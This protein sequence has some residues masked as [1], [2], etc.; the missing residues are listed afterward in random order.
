M[1]L[2]NS[3][4]ES[5]SIEQASLND[6]FI[7]ETHDEKSSLEK[8]TSMVDAV[9]ER[10]EENESTLAK[11]FDVSKEKLK[12]MKA[13]YLDIVYLKSF[14]DTALEINDTFV[15]IVINF[16]SKLRDHLEE[17]YNFEP[18]ECKEENMFRDMGIKINN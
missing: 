17:I 9:V 3:D 2:D 12:I 16:L 5:T 4:N 14:Y 13:L 6:A 1:S 8:F 7:E 18:S 15:G 10:I 11:M